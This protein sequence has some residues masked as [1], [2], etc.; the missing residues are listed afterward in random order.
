MRVSPLI[1]ILALVLYGAPAAALQEPIEEP[2]LVPETTEET[3]AEL[4]STELPPPDV[5]PLTRTDVEAWLDGFMPYALAKGGVAGAVVVVVADGG[6]V[7]AKG[8]G[9]S[10]LEA[11]TPVDPERTLF[12]PGSVSK[13]FTWTAVMQLVEQG[14]LDLDADVNEYLDFEI[15]EREG[16]EPITLRDIMTHTPGFE[17]RLKNLITPLPENL[18][19]LGESLASWVP[20]RIFPAGTTPAYSNYA[21]G[22]AG[23]IVERVSG[24]SFDEYVEE[25]IFAPL[26]MNDSTFRQPLPER[27]EAQ[28]SKGYPDTSGEAKPFEIVD[29]S[30]AGSLSAPGADMAKFML[31]HLNGGEYQGARILEPATA[32]QMHR[33]LLTILP[34]LNR[35]ALGFYETNINGHNVIAHGGDTQW[36]HSYLHLFLD[37]GIGLYV[38][39]NSAGKQGASGSIRTALFEQFADRYL[40]GPDPS[41][42]VDPETARAHAAMMAGTYQ[43]SRRVET[44]FLA[45]LNLFGHTKVVDNGDGTITVP[46]FTDLSGAPQVWREIRPYLWVEERGEERL[47]AVVQDG[48]VKRF[49]IDAIS[50]FMVFEP[51]PWW[52]SSAWLLPLTNASLAALA[53]TAVLWPVKAIVRRRYAQPPLLTGRD[54][55]A[56]RWAKFASLATLVVLG[57][58]AATISAMFSD[59]SLLGGSMDP[60][61]LL[62]QLVSLVVFPGS[63]LIALWHAARVWGGTRRWPAKLWSIVLVVAFATLLWVAVAFNLVGFGT[64]Y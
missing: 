58:W 10:D 9:Y 24:Q 33:T 7:L 6:V 21:T 42:E 11:R 18:Q 52:K 27:L 17:E 28:M 15:P 54:L 59:L 23:Y 45:A 57:G 12:R 37:E 51:V 3:P 30:P 25:H 48:A 60:L 32:R 19:P 16:D 35:M 8:Y 47:A 14:R 64:H 55:S 22:L 49:S 4:P 43:V 40:P 13:L 38:S 39:M 50:P 46:M 56:Y 61:I 53:L 31:A 1:P 44:T 29:P 41:G 2:P 62:L 34:P 36:F 63:L 20:E 5:H 26:G